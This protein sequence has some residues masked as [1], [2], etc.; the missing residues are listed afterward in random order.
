MNI[1]ARSRRGRGWR[2]PRQNCQR[3]FPAVALP[4]KRLR[5][6]L[7]LGLFSSPQSVQHPERP[8]LSDEHQQQFL[9]I[10]ETLPGRT[11]G[12]CIGPAPPI[13]AFGKLLFAPQTC[14]FSCKQ[15]DKSPPP[16]QRST[17]GRREGP[18]LAERREQQNLTTGPLVQTDGIPISGRPRRCGLKAAE[19]QPQR[20]RSF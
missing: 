1:R 11:L 18:R 7:S 15:L 17:A 5:Q 6:Q 8:F 16:P 12:R 9:Q 2:R 3:V 20:S 4:G 10:N 14:C 19:I 13:E